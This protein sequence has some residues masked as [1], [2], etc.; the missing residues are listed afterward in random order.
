ME[1]SGYIAI[2]IVLFHAP[3]LYFNGKDTLLIILGELRNNAS[4]KYL[5]N[6]GLSDW[7][8]SEVKLDCSSGDTETIFRNLSKESEM[9]ADIQFEIP[10][11]KMQPPSMDFQ[12]P[13]H[14]EFNS[15]LVSPK[16]GSL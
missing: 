8:R 4:T 1:F 10:S 9:K 11:I 7:F 3:I 6:T 5:Q 13:S 2:C 12:S 16:N 14:S 15:F